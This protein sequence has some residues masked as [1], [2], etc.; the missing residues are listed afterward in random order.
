MQYKYFL[1]YL[2]CYSPR[3]ISKGKQKNCSLLLLLLPNLKI[4]QYFVIL[5]IFFFPS[6]SYEEYAKQLHTDRSNFLVL[7]SYVLVNNSEVSDFTIVAS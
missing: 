2:G 7:C 5:C 3:N 6:H 1:L 4:K